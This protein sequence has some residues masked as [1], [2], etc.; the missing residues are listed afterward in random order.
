MRRHVLAILDV[1]VVASSLPTIQMTLQIHPDQISWV[2]TAYLIAEVVAIPLTGCLTRLLSMRW[3]FA[4]AL[5]VFTAASI[6]CA[7]SGSFGDLV[8][9]RILHGFS[10]GTLIP[11][12]FSAVFIL[13]PSNRRGSEHARA[14]SCTSSLPLSFRAAPGRGSSLRAASRLISTKRSDVHCQ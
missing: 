10:G 3:L 13:F 12:V 5:A 2:Q 9:W 1:Q 11:A 4:S 14:T 6:G 8:A 7:F